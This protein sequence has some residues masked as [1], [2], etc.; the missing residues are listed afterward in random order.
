MKYKITD[1]RIGKR[2]QKQFDKNRQNIEERYGSKVA[3]K[4][5]DDF[6]GAKEQIK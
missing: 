1:V 4:Y 6:I 2:A 5:V 3:D